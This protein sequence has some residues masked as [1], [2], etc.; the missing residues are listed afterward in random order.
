MGSHSPSSTPPARG[1]RAAGRRWG[2]WGHPPTSA[3]WWRFSV[4]PMPAGSRASSSTPTAAPRSW[5]PCFRSRF[6]WGE[7]HEH[8]EIGRRRPM[9]RVT[10]AL[11]TAFQ[12]NEMN[13]YRRFQ[14]RTLAATLML[15]IALAAVAAPP[16]QAQNSITLFLQTQYA[17]SSFGRQVSFSMEPVY[18]TGNQLTGATLVVNL[19]HGVSFVS[20]D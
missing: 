14:L 1:T 6:S 20:A 10:T 4:P 18:A 12:E 9:N 16:A 5:T 17:R 15:V 13:R 19:P 7:G 11:A 3:M 8:F 2:G